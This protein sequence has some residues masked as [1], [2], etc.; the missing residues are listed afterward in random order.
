MMAWSDGERINVVPSVSRR[1]D[2]YGRTI[3]NYYRDFREG[4]ENWYG[5]CAIVR[6]RC[7]CFEYEADRF[8]RQGRHLEALKEM[9]MAAQCVLPDEDEGLEFEDAQWLD[10]QETLYW[11]RNVQEF[12]RYN[13]RCIDFCKRDTRL[14]PIYNGSLVERDYHNYLCALGQWVHEG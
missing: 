2:D 7:R 11:H 13:L 1:I 5:S 14:W 12:L 4:D 9:M 8:W 10:P 3:R 6:D